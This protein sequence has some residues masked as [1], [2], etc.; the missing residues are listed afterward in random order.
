MQRYRHLN[1]L[2]ATKVKVLRCE[3]VENIKNLL[4]IDHMQDHNEPRL[5]QLVDLLFSNSQNTSTAN[6]VGVFCNN[7]K[8]VVN[9]KLR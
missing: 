7:D 6:E 9:T 3:V 2:K 8:I 5:R 4:K 1:T